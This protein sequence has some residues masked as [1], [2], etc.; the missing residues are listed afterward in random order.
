MSLLTATQQQIIKAVRFPRL[1]RR[2]PLSIPESL[3][4]KLCS[5]GCSH[6]LGDKWNFCPFISLQ[7][8]CPGC[9]LIHASSLGSHQADSITFYTLTFD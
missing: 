4:I 2:S 9:D 5:P 8:L 7:N 1:L 6:G 3:L